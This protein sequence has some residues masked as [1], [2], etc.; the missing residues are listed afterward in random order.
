MLMGLIITVYYTSQ[1]LPSISERTYVAQPTQLPLF[2]GTAVFAFEG[3]GLVS[4][5]KQWCQS[6]IRD[7]L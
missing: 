2:F 7:C 3:I 4:Q 5:S 1:D 6:G